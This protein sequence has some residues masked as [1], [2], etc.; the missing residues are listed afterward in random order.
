MTTVAMTRDSPI[1]I[2][3]NGINDDELLIISASERT[4]NT[5]F[6]NAS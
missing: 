4:N 5:M 3:G 6:H 1:K 2:K